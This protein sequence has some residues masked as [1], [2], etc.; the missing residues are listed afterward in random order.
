LA[1]HVARMGVTR[2]AQKILVGKLRIN[3]SE[4]LGVDLRI[5]LKLM[6]KK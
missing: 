1:A 4:D 3:H 6:L 2:N 5:I